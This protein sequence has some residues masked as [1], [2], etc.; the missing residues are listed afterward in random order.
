MYG[1]PPPKGAAR[2]AL[3]RLSESVQKPADPYKPGTETPRELALM[4]EIE[5]LHVENSRLRRALAVFT[6][7]QEKN[8]ALSKRT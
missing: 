8:H 1:G 2:E 3:E 7:E 6:E 4:Q 5:R